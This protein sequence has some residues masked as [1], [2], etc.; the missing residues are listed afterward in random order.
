MSLSLS[1]DTLESSK[2][3]SSAVDLPSLRQDPTSEQKIITNA[4]AHGEDG[5]RQAT[6]K[7][8]GDYLKKY[9]SLFTLTPPKLKAIVTAFEEVLHR[10]LAEHNQTVVRSKR[11]L[12]P[13]AFEVWV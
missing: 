5:Q 7:A 13:H 8:I 10:G 1:Q 11:V 2:K 9:E 12:L 3:P 6:G 4:L